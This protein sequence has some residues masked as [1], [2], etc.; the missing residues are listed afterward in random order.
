[1]LLTADDVTNAV[2]CFDFARQRLGMPWIPPKDRQIFCKQMK[3]LR[4]SDPRITWSTMAKVIMWSAAHKRRPARITWLFQ[5]LNRAWRDGWLP[6]LRACNDEMDV[7]D[8]IIEALRV[9]TDPGWR[10]RLME[11]RGAVRLQRLE[12]WRSCRQVA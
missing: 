8:G 2:S 5:D 1:M 9:E 4:E 3:N 10:Q 12:E 11:A 6:E 7:E